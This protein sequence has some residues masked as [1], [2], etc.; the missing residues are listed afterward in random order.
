[1]R[2]FGSAAISRLRRCDF[3]RRARLR[4]EKIPPGRVEPN[5][6]ASAIVK[7]GG[8]AKLWCT[9]STPAARAFGTL[10]VGRRRPFTEICPC[11]GLTRPAATRAK[12]VFPAPFCPTTA[13]I[14]SGANSIERPA[15]AVTGPYWTVTPLQ[16][17]AGTKDRCIIFQ[18]RQVTSGNRAVWT[19]R[20][21][22][23]QSS[24]LKGTV[25][26][27][28]RMAARAACTA[29][30]AASDLALISSGPWSA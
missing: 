9:S 16:L 19:A 12:V 13:W 3:Q 10:P 14:K 6:I 27:P 30:Q 29:G 28:S 5:S 26:E 24:V 20:F 17:S 4:P 22:C 21:R 11:S 8:R 7:E 1:M 25:S 23:I 15:I 18:P 2:L